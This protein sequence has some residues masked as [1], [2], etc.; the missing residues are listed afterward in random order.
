L[1]NEIEYK[2]TVK[3]KFKFENLKENK[4]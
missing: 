2:I 3:F 4:I 1:C